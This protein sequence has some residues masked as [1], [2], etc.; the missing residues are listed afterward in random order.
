MPDEVGNDVRS[1]KRDIEALTDGTAVQVT[2]RDVSGK[3]R[4]QIVHQHWQ[5]CAQTPPAGSKFTPETG[6]T[7]DVVKTNESCPDNGA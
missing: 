5:V 7:F 3:D 6:V 4:R 2:L 1:A